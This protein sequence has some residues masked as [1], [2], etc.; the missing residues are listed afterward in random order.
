VTEVCPENASSVAV[1]APDSAAWVSAECRSWVQRPA[2]AC[3]LEDLG[4]PPI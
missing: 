4:G 3:L 1:L 2:S